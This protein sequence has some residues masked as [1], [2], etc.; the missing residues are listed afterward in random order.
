MSE[1]SARLPSDPQSGQ[2]PHTL[3]QTGSSQAS[4]VQGH[5]QDQCWSV[6]WG[7]SPG[8]AQYYPLTNV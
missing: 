2:R 6:A 1:V 8:T 4:K 3:T 7:S 5:C